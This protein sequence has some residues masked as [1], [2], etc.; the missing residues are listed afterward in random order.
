MDCHAPVGA[1]SCDFTSIE[2]AR[3]G[4][5]AAIQVTLPRIFSLDCRDAVRCF[6]QWTAASGYSPSSQ[7]RIYLVPEYHQTR[8][9]V[10]PWRSKCFYRKCSALTVRTQS[11]DST[12]GLLRSAR[13]FGVVCIAAAANG[14][15]RPCG[16]RR[17]EFVR[18]VKKKP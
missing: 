5:D 9:G 3:S 15:P 7:F 14:L 6:Y 2:I 13:S 12:R 1:L 8:E 16:A 17:F 4:S 10:S 11:A 18:G